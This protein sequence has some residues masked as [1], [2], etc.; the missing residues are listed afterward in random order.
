M[1]QYARTKGSIALITLTNP[2]VN[3]L[4][5]AVRKGITEAVARA[6]KDTRVKAV[7]LCGENGKFC[8]G[9]DIRE[10]A[11]AM[12][13]PPLVPMIHAIEAGE[14][15][16]VAAIEEMALG[17]GLELALGCHYRVAHAKARLGLPEVTLGLLP[18]AG[19]TQRLPR[20]TGI[21]AALDLITTGRHISAQ[22]ALKLGIV[23]RVTEG[24]AVEAAVELALSVVGRP[25]APRRLSNHATPLPADLDGV[26][27]EVLVQVKRRARGAMAPV[28]C[29]K[30]VRAAA[31]LPYSRGLECERELMNTL[32]TS[33]QARALQY[34]FFAQRAAGKWSLPNGA[35]WDNS[36]PRA[37]HTAGVIG[38][39]TMGRGIAVCLVKAG[40][41]VVAV[42]TEEKQLDSGRRAVRG[43]LERDAKRRGVTAPL[44]MI[45]FTLSMQQLRDVDLVIEA[46]FEDMALKKSVF[47]ELSR[48]CR[49]NA[50]LCTNTSGLDVDELASVT[51]RPPL[52]VG[53]HFFAPAHVMKLLEV[54]C[55]PRSSPETVATA[56]TLGKRLG[57]VSVAVGNCPGFVGNRMLKLYLDQ[58][59]FLLEE[60]AS[61]EQVD[62][63][64]EEFGFALGIFKVADLSGLDIGWRV[65]K[66]AGL[67]GPDVDPKFPSRHRQGRRYCPLPD[68]LC[69]QGRLGQKSGRGWYLYDSAGGKEARPDPAISSFLQEYRLRYG[70]SARRI[71]EQEVV[72]RC[73]FVLANEG[74]RI[75][76]DGMAAAPEDID[77]VYVFGYGWPRH[78]GGPMFHAAQVGLATVLQ[79][80]EFYHRQNPDIPHLQPSTLLRRLVGARSPP[81]QQWKQHIRSINSQL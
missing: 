58:A 46:V 34:C 76:E 18:A 15:P 70:I 10:F 51:D 27:E 80:L 31:E 36:R 52:V 67:I 41:S 40:I 26:F 28:A 78:R 62:Q 24:N 69:E 42:E 19:G 22:E 53:M 7:V 75:L 9:A 29:A 47:A 49:P 50:L 38:L 54:I 6:F 44:H 1:A 33:G 68:L 64:L 73:V 12:S 14:K 79:R 77:M 35:R 13:G 74:F 72:E 56:M 8:G 48:V 16:V 2:P 55:G 32:F 5:A 11:K 61:P 57:K 25:L 63:A 59:H 37:V 4:S 21:P 39:G 45:T 23:D 81:M 30:A 71:T 65:R 60:G 17:G 3:A 43:M 20:L 66:A